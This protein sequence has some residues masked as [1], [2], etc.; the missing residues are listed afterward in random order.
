M[1]ETLSSGSVD[2]L[3]GKGHCEL[4]QC[5][6]VRLLLTL[7]ETRPHFPLWGHGDNLGL[8]L[9]LRGMLKDLKPHWLFPPCPT[10]ASTGHC[11]VRAHRLTPIG[12][13]GADLD[14]G[15]LAKAQMPS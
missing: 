4:Q 13:G 8:S 10:V 5:T 7:E 11:P 1:W 6:Q 15:A 3:C 14:Y 12:P 2:P 9:V